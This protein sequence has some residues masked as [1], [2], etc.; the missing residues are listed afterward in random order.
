MTT[1]DQVTSL[2][3]T[4]IELRDELHPEIPEALLR[5]IVV[6]HAEDGD[7]PSLHRRVQR[8][9]EE[10]LGQERGAERATD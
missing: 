8:A 1:S 9:L 6:A 5:E 10:S 4:L 7:S 3:E 2:M